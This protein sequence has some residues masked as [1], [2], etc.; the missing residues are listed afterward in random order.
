MS[1]VVAVVVAAVVRGF[2]LVVVVAPRGACVCDCGLV[3]SD[4]EDEMM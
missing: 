2:R 3:L 4:D 1:V